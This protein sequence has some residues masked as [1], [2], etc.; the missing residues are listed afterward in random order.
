MA[1][2][3]P[4]P[5]RRVLLGLL[6]AAGCSGPRVAPVPP[7]VPE[8]FYQL[9]SDA[10]YKDGLVR[11]LGDGRGGLRVT[12]LDH[13]GGSFRLSPGGDGA[14]T[15]R[16]ARID[17]EDVGRSLRGEGRLT[18]A[19]GLEGECV[20]WVGNI[21]GISRD[22]RSQPWTLRPASADEARRALAKLRKR[23]PGRLESLGL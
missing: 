12:L 16:E 8:G 13:F 21:L 1:A 20:V 19:G 3:R 9:D 22:H 4:F 2:G 14:F 5:S 17:I 23:Y 18:A 7:P 11:V 15:I 6:L 10:F